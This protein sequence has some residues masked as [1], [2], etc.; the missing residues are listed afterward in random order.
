MDVEWGPDVEWGSGPRLDEFLLARIAEDKRV[1]TDAAE[2]AGEEWTE[3]VGAGIAERREAEH[4]ARFDPARV[5]AECTAKRGMVLACRE[6][7]PDMQFLGSRPRGR[8][9]FPLQPRDQHQLAALALALLA[10]PYAGHRDYRE[11]WRP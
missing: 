2:V 9:D 4:V 10:L 7:R 3:G 8:E 5:H 11:E 6:S 1:A